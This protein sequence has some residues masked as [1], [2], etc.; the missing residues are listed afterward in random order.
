MRCS[1]RL[2]GRS[3]DDRERIR[4]LNDEVRRE[5]PQAGDGVHWVFTR[6]VIGLD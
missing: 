6:G 4:A 5:G 3:Q 1:V 2:M